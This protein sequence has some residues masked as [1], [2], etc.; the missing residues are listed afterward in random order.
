MKGRIKAGEGTLIGNAGEYY[1][2]AELLKGG[3]VAALAPQNAPSFDILATKQNRTVRIRVKTKSHDFHV[4]QWSA[5]KD[6]TIFRNLSKDGDFTVLVGLAMENKD[7]RFYVM[8]TH[9]IDKWLQEDFKKWVKTPGRNN[10]PHN[11]TNPKR[12]LSE[13]QQEL[14]SYLNRWDILWE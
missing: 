12:N 2:M 5:K 11:P 14:S 6:G 7:L 1:V 9:T 13:E 4:W 3:A 10:R 8:P